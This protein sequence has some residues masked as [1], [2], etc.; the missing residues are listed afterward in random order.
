MWH[1]CRNTIS[2]LLVQYG[3]WNWWSLLDSQFK[4]TVINS[5]FFLLAGIIYALSLSPWYR[6]FHS[7]IWSRTGIIISC[8]CSLVINLCSISSLS[9]LKLPFKPNRYFSCLPGCSAFSWFPSLVSYPV[10]V[11]VFLQGFSWFTSLLPYPGLVLL[12]WLIYPLLL[13]FFS[14]SV[15]LL[16]FCSSC[17]FLDSVRCKG[18]RVR[19]C[20]HNCKNCS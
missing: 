3:S 7:P 2:L 9:C 13:W 15:N 6:P 10:N 1:N 16:C 8:L 20:F 14:N 18:R 5:S 12:L 19:T 11:P 4:P 17:I